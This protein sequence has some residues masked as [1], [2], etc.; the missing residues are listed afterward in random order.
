[1]AQDVLAVLNADLGTKETKRGG[2]YRLTLVHVLALLKRRTPTPILQL[3]ETALDISE[4]LYAEDAK[5]S[6][7]NPEAL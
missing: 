2:D 4:L 1:M 7:K 6:P 3:I 5:R